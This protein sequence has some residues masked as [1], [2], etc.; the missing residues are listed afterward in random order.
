MTCDSAA[1]HASCS[2]SLKLGLPPFGKAAA[3]NG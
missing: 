1:N 2:L 3:P